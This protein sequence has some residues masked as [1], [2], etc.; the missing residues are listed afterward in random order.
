MT[1]TKQD[2]PDNIDEYIAA[3]PAEVQEILE[4]IRK[5]IR[6]SAPEAQE[7][8]KYKM[9]TF[10]LH[11]NLVFFAAFKR[12]ISFYPPVTGAVELR[13]EVSAYEGPKGSLKF[14]LDR[15]IPYELIRRI[16]KFRV[17]ENMD[18]V[19]EKRKRK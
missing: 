3:F 14:P 9:P 12:H 19:E 11:G 10:T 8:I 6:E 15:P 2:T 4:K 1:S 7:T 5:M 17:Q 18:R 13:S 16:V